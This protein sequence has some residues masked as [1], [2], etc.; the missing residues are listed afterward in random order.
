MN[1]FLFR[2]TNFNYSNFR[3]SCVK[4]LENI[5]GFATAQI[6]T[7]GHRFVE[8]IVE[9]SKKHKLMMDLHSA[10]NQISNS[11]QSREKVF[12]YFYYIFL[13]RFLFI[14]LIKSKDRSKINGYFRMFECDKA[15]NICSI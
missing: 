15:R 11:V 13:S 12:Q 8:K 6:D 5:E 10:Q 7:I 2:K 4:S 9:Y 14:K 3:P 1:I